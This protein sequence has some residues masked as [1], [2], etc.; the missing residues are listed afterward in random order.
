MEL[1]ILRRVVR[2]H[3][4]NCLLNDKPL[5]FWCLQNYKALK[6]LLKQSINPNEEICIRDDKRVTALWLAKHQTGALHWQ[7]VRRLLR[8]YGAASIRYSDFVSINIH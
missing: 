3:G 1:S 2:K 7:K 4:A 5:I 8:R 6:W